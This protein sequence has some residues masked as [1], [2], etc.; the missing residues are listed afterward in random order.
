MQCISFFYV[1]KLGSVNKFLYLCRMI[2]KYDKETLNYKK[3]TGKITL[4]SIGIILLI[5]FGISLFTLRNI[6][7]VK[8]ISQETRA[9]ILREADK[10]NEFTPY[11]LKE[12]ILELNIRYPHIVLAQ[13][14]L[15]SGTGKSQMFKTNH[16]LFGLKEAKRRPTTALGTDNNHAYYDNWKESVLDYAFLQAA[17]MH[18]I[19]TEDEYYQYLG[20]YYAEDPTYVEKL[21]K[22]VNKMKL[23]DLVKS[24]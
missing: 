19:K 17:Y 23:K 4:I 14:E 11:K 3:V 7:E 20:Q 5:S 16:N 6:N 8:Y 24:K 21:K 2:Y 1:K 22:I 15:E 18:E 13:A 10:A 9:I 12:Y